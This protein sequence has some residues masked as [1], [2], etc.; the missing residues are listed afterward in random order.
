MSQIKLDPKLSAPVPTRLKAVDRAGAQATASAGG[1]T[2][3]V[4][5]AQPV[6]LS[7]EALQLGA[8]SDRL[9][10][11]PDSSSER[12]ESLRALVASGDYQPDARAIAVNLARFEWQL[13]G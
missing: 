5:A 6:K 13:Y 12:L 9:A 3:A 11:V 4:A 2:P 8:L 10:A 1:P 7:G